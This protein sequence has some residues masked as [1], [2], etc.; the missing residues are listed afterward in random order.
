M[1]KKLSIPIVEVAVNVI[2]RPGLILTVYND[3]WG[4]FTLPMTKR[5]R[6][7][8]PTR[9]RGIRNEPWR[10]AAVRAATELLGRTFAPS[11]LPSLLMKV[12]KAYQ[13]S[14]RDGIWKE[15][16]FQVFSM[17]LHPNER[18]L[19]NVT[20]EWLDPG[21]ILDGKIRPVS[22]TA[23]FILLQLRAKKHL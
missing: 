4:A 10:D 14:D 22:E 3:K 2:F 12:E 15:Y 9:S 5:R 13:Q 23:Q 21:D 11:E 16:R 19:D 1:A 17:N 6:W 20:A 8:D 7:Q 18:L